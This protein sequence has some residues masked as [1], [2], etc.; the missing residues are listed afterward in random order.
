[1]I[2]HTWPSPGIVAKAASADNHGGRMVHCGGSRAS[3]AQGCKPVL[4]PHL[5]V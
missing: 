5:E 2:G 4:A 3:A 1:V